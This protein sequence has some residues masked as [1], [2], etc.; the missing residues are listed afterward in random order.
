MQRYFLYGILACWGFMAC[1][2]PVHYTP[3]EIEDEVIDFTEIKDRGKLVVLTENTSTSYYLY[4]GHPVGYDF[5]LLSAFA[6]DHDLDLQIKVIQ[7]MNDMFELLN[8]GEGDVIACNLTV[9]SDRKELMAFT[10]PLTTTKQVLVQRKPDGWRKMRKSTVEDS[11]ISDIQQLGGLDIHVHEYSSFYSRLQN[12]QDEIGQKINIIP[13]SGD[14]DSEGLIRMVVEG[15][16][17]YTVT[18]ENMAMLNQTYY[19]EL[20]VSTSISLNQSIAWAVRK[21]SDSLLVMLNSWL[22]DHK[23]RKRIAYTHRKYFESPK[24]QRDRV[25]S[26]YSSISGNKI[27]RYDEVIKDVAVSIGWDWRMLAALI[28]QESRFNPEAKSWAG[29]FGLMQMMPQTAAR[30]GIDSTQVE[31]ANVVAGGRYLA[32]LEKMWQDDVL[33][34]TERKKFILAS[35]NAGPGHVFDAMALAQ[36]FEKDPQDWEQVEPFLIKK[37]EPK[38]YTMD[39]VKHGYCRGRQPVAYVKNVMNS[40]SHYVSLN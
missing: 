6:S 12:V 28:Y 3:L 17:D 35:Y 24:D 40:Y 11:L 36:E 8:E 26:E 38:Y 22:N 27:S 39:V 31:D 25:T 29:A 7:D 37:S 18:D 34:S 30:F 15:E 20:D 14:V 4:K 2:E 23:N 10:T 32:Y 1:N 16:I 19:P 5:E 21:S 13:A 33:D 9:T